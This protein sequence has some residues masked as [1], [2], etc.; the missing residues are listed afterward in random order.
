MPTLADLIAV[1]SEQEILASLVARANE[2]A[3]EMGATLPTNWHEGAEYRTA[4]QAAARTQADFELLIP[5]LIKGG[6]TELAEGEWLDMAAANEGVPRNL[7]SFARHTVTLSAQPGFGPYTVVPGQVRASTP[8]GLYFQGLSGGNLA[9]GGTLQI[10]VIAEHPGAIY[11]V[12]AGQ[13]SIL[14]TPL[15]GVSIANPPDSLVA[16]GRDRET[17]AAL[18]ERVRLRWPLVSAT[19]RVRDAYA[20]IALDAH[21]DILKVRVRD[22]LP[23]GQNTLDVVLWGAGGLSAQGL[24]AAR[25]ELDRLKGITANVGT[26][27][28]DWVYPATV[29]DVPVTANLRVRTGYAAAANS[30]AVLALQALENRYPIGGEDG[31][32]WRSQVQDALFVV[33]SAVPG[34]VQNVALSA[35]ADDINLSNVQVVRFTPITINITEV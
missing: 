22:D 2:V 30:R 6:F 21:P 27:V 28:A 31:K 10:T 5:D 13:I 32:L 1:R 16:A 25:A 15:P 35:P 18:R 3:L 29:L 14:N 7:E 12:A 8:G 9:Q 17:D 33:D 19:E 24:A 11:N 4:L 34:M 20:K 23:R 26:P